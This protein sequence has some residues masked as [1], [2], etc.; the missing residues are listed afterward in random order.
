M[1][2]EMESITKSY[3]PC[4]YLSART[5]SSPAHSRRRGTPVRLSPTSC[6]S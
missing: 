6:A 3:K 5:P 1:T 4:T 2:D